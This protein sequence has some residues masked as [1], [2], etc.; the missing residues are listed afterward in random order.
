MSKEMSP[1]RR[2]EIAAL[3]GSDERY[4]Y[5]CL[6]GRRDMGPAEA[7]RLETATKGELRRWDLC[8]HTWYLIW[9]DL[10]GT[11]GAPR[12][13]ASAKRDASTCEG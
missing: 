13:G 1:A 5:Q 9:P 8:Q 4:L 6:T 12:P 10:V 2:K 11:D 7:M 3:Y